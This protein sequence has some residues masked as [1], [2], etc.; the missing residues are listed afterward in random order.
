[1]TII[2]IVASIS[3]T[4]APAIAPSELLFAL[5]LLDNGDSDTDADLET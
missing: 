2:T 4:T 5:I 1:M 3:E